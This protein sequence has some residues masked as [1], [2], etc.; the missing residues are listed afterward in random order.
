MLNNEYNWKPIAECLPALLA[1]AESEICDESRDFT[2]LRPEQEFA[3]RG[4]HKPASISQSLLHTGTE[5][6]C[7]GPK[8]V[9]NLRQQKAEEGI[10]QHVLSKK[11][12]VRATR[13][14]RRA[15]LS[16]PQAT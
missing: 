1:A 6:G 16:E 11:T 7:C 4:Q 8:P 10:T 12:S 13:S 5:S 2:S 15:E 3:L 9:Q 14:H